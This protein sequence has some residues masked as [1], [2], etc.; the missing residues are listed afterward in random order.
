M[1]DDTNTNYFEAQNA[2]NEF[3]KNRPLPNE[4][5]ELMGNKPERKKSFFDTILLAKKEKREEESKKYTYEY[6]RFKHWEQKMLPYVQDD[7]RI[8]TATERLDEWQKS[9]K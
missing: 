6:K 7:G 8:L 5:N 4:E 2:F 3:W 1:M 9:R